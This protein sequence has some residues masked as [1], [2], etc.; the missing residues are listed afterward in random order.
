MVYNRRTLI[1]KRI[2]TMRSIIRKTRNESLEKHAIEY[3]ENL[4]LVG[5]L[6][7][8]ETFDKSLI[9]K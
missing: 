7:R 8:K 3:L 1:A 5:K 4:K 6:L 2:R 9:K